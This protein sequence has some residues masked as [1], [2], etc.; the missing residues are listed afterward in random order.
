MAIGKITNNLAAGKY[1][2]LVEHDNT[3]LNT[4]LITLEQ[5]LIS[6]Y[7]AQ[8]ALANKIVLE[9]YDWRLLLDALDVQINSGTEESIKAAAI[10]AQVQKNKLDAAITEQTANNAAILSDEKLRN[11]LQ[12]S[13]KADVLEVWCADLIDDLPNG[14]TVGLCE[15]AGYFDT[16]LNL[17]IMRPA[18]VGEEGDK[19]TAGAAAEYSRDGVT[20]AQSAIPPSTLFYTYCLAPWW[21]IYRS[22]YRVGTIQTLDR[23]NDKCSVI[24]EHQAY[25]FFGLNIP[26]SK[27]NIFREPTGDE[28]V[29]PFLS[30]TPSEGIQTLYS[31]VAIEYMNCDARAFAERDRVLLEF[32][33]KKAQKQTPFVIG[34]EKEPRACFFGDFISNPKSDTETQVTK[35]FS[36]DLTEPLGYSVQT[37]VGYQ[38]GAF[39]DFYTYRCAKL[40]YI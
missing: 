19:V 26:T 25:N 9:R 8:N 18:F 28:L 6:R 12:A 39:L 38:W 34:F 30:D 23:I 20:V 10:A 21:L 24:L 31:D 36:R 7:S 16:Q 14:L 3:A 40:L 35:T 13:K 4:R 17:P 1:Q 15:P 27:N 2:V 37:P 32:R 11:T 29:L 22:H 33:G 5:Q